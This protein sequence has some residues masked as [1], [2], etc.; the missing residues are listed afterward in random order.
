MS[1]NQPE[2]PKEVDHRRKTEVAAGAAEEGRL[3]R[4]VEAMAPGVSPEV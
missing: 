3:I 4:Q 2:P 1:W